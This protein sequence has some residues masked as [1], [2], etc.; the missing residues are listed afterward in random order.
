MFSVPL[1]GA[2]CVS[3]VSAHLLGREDQADPGMG[4]PSLASCGD[5]AELGMLPGT[6]S[7]FSV[8]LCLP[9]VSE[10]ELVA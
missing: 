9:P 5:Q 1:P 10:T 8:G 3:G 6:C 4:F 7:V 2:L